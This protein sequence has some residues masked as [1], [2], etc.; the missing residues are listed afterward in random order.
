MSETHT[1]YNTGGEPPKTIQALR[2]RPCSLPAAD[3]AYKKPTP[4]ELAALIK[5]AGWSQND[6]AKLT[7]VSY[8]PQKGSPTVRRWKAPEDKKDHRDIPYATWR[9][10][11]IAAGVCDIN[12]DLTTLQNALWTSAK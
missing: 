2:N 8:N 3:P 7:G 4:E 10:L 11:L 9:L 1:Q 6:V 5:I 12:Q